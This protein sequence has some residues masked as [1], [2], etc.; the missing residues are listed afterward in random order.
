MTKPKKC[1]PGKYWCFTD[2][3]CK[4]IPMGYHVM[5]GGRLMKDEDHEN[6][7]DGK[8]KGKKNG[9]GNGGNG[10]GDSNGSTG[11]ILY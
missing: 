8:K 3:K 9:N 4:K 2:K 1:P 11:E 7:E 5:G 10:N 6:G